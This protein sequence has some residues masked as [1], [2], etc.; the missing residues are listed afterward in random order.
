MKRVATSMKAKFNKYWGSF[1]VI[2]KLIMIAHVLDPRYKL[3][4]AKG[5]MKK[6]NASYSTI[7]SIQGELKRILMRMYEEYK[8][9]DTS[10]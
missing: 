7:E 3:Q 4:W 5:A 1:E 6:V 2:N 8:G 10:E 9:D